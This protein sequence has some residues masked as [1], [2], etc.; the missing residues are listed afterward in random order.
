MLRFA[1]DKFPCVKSGS[2]GVC[3]NIYE[4]GCTEYRQ[5]LDLIYLGAHNPEADHPPTGPT[6]NP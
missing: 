4:I 1:A 2:S 3:E 5:L 6:V